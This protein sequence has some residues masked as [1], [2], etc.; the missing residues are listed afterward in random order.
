MPE[1]N[2]TF[3]FLTIRQP[4]IER[5]HAKPAYEIPAHVSIRLE[6]SFGMNTEPEMLGDTSHL[7]IKMK[8]PA[9]V[10][11]PHLQHLERISDEAFADALQAIASEL[12]KRAQSR[13][14]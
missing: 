6:A 2:D 8:L 5:V 14:L 3:R 9:P 10:D 12:R 13:H 4:Q 11:T 1:I 7:S